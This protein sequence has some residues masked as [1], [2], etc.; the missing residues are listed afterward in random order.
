MQESEITLKIDGKGEL[1]IDK[2]DLI[3]NPTPESE[4]TSAADARSK[5]ATLNGLSGGE[6]DENQQS[7]HLQDID[8]ARHKSESALDA[9]KDE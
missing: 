1:F 9:E 2:V 6:F 5:S 3:V 4:S 8:T 7:L